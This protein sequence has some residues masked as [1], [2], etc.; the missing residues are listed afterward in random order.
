MPMHHIV[1]SDIKKQFHPGVNK[2][3]DAT[4]IFQPGV[5]FAPTLGLKNAC[6]GVLSRKEV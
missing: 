1:Y 5:N 3:F 4:R 2:Y 6:N